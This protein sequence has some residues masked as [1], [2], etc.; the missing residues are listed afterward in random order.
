MYCKLRDLNT[1]LLDNYYYNVDQCMRGEDEP[2]IVARQDI[3][4]A[5]DRIEHEHILNGLAVLVEEHEL[6]D[7]WGRLNI[8]NDNLYQ[9]ELF[10]VVLGLIRF[11]P[12][13]T[14]KQSSN[15]SGKERWAHSEGSL[16]HYCGFGNSNNPNRHIRPVLERLV[17]D[18]IYSGDANGGAMKAIFD[19]KYP[20]WRWAYVNTYKVQEEDFVSEDEHKITDSIV[21]NMASDL[22][23]TLYRTYQGLNSEVNE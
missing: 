12:P 11:S 3:L 1:H 6:W 23:V 14:N 10:G 18:M 9:K 20:E 13:K 2:Y 5:F 8:G 7:T 21:S 19:N 4:T 17:D 16:L 15:G 22:V